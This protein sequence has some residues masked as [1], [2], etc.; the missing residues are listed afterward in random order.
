MS[1]IQS[2]NNLSR[3]YRE[4]MK[5]FFILTKVNQ[6]ETV[7]VIE[8]HFSI[9]LDTRNVPISAQRKPGS[10]VASNLEREGGYI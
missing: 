1:K 7:R 8:S 6:C 10:W 3:S 5:G 2:F 4:V 9:E